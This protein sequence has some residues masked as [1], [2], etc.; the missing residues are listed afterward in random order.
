MNPASRRD[1]EDYWRAWRALHRAAEPVLPSKPMDYHE[2]G[3]IGGRARSK[4]ARLAE[5]IKLRGG[6]PL[7]DRSLEWTREGRA[8]LSKEA[9]NGT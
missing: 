9:G 6:K 7:P 5:R 1:H 8:T 2:L 4:E 3:R